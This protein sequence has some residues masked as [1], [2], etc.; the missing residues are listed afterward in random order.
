MNSFDARCPYFQKIRGQV[1]W[2]ANETQLQDAEADTG[3]SLPHQSQINWK[4]NGNTTRGSTCILVDGKPYYVQ[5][6]NPGKL[7][8]G[9]RNNCLI[10][11]LRQCI[12]VQC[13]RTLVRADLQSLYGFHAGRA[14]VTF[15]S[16]LDVEEHCKDILLSLLRHNTSRVSTK[17]NPNEYCVVALSEDM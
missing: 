11:S 14:K 3:G 13:D 12:G 10:D 1:T 2:D 15:D 4:I 17:Y 5:Y 16:Y 9:E 7:S 8:E 6:G